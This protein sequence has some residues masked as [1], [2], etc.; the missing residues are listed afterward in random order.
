MI[1]RGNKY[2]G[3]GMHNKYD[4]KKHIN[5]D[6]KKSVALSIFLS[7]SHDFESMQCS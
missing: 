3:T 6:D 7:V 5:L 2:I 1:P 4:T